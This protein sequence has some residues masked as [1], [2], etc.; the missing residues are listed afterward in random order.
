[1]VNHPCNSSNRPGVTLTIIFCSVTVN[2]ES[3]AA[4]RVISGVPQ[5]S[6][7]G[8]LLF[9]IYIN[10]IT[11]IPLNNG[12]SMLLYAD[13]IL[14]YRRVKTE[15]DYHLLQQDI[16][17]LE[18]WLLQ[19]YLELN[20]KYMTISRK[21]SELSHYQLYITNQAMEKVSTF[22]YLGVWLSDNLSWSAHIQKSSK[23]ALKQA[24]SMYRR[25]YQYSSA[26]T[27]KQL[28]LSFV[29]PHLEYAAPV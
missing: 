10:G 22:K 2:G 11:Q 28:Y 4:T 24:G 16:S 12:T 1:M 27:L 21:H 15:Y 7:L 20:A 26:D 6:V 5:G 8:P 23:I 19:N 13:D 29:R 14:L 25:F 17:T 9:L 3:S 18:N